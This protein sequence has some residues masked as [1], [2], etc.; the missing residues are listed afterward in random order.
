MILLRTMEIKNLFGVG[1]MST[2][3]A[4]WDDNTK[5]TIR[6]ELDAKWNWDDVYVK[7]AEIHAM[8]DEVKHP[9][10]FIIYP[11]AET[12]ALPP[13]SLQH[14]RELPK[15]W[16]SNMGVTVIV[17]NNTVIDI[18][19]GLLQQIYQQC[20]RTIINTH[21]LEDARAIISKRVQLAG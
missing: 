17:A 8:M 13:S 2:M 15:L 11:A 7:S 21:T 4:F 9:V 14:L 12:I 20:F 19:M 5:T 3:Q 18:V 6:I 16:H 1:M 10:N